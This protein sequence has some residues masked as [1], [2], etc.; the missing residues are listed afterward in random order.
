MSMQGSWQLK[1]RIAGLGAGLFLGSMSALVK[2]AVP[3][4][5]AGDVSAS[6]AWWTKVCGFTE[7]FSHGDPP[8]YAGIARDGA[9]LHIARVSDAEVA[10]MV[11]EQTMVRIAVDDVAAFFAEY[12]ERG[13]LVHPNGGLQ[14]KPWGTTEFAAIDPGGVCVTFSE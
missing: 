1:I 11:G 6:L 5:P 14:K 8:G 2:A 10:K 9:S 4:L 7:M 3:I 13:G 12:R